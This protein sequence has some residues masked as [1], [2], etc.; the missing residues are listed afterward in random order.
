MQYLRSSR[1]SCSAIGF[2]ADQ[3]EE[4][5]SHGRKCLKLG[6]AGSVSLRITVLAVVP[7]ERSKR[8]KGFFRAA[9][10]HCQRREERAHLLSPVSCSSFRLAAIRASSAHPLCNRIGMGMSSE[11]ASHDEGNQTHSEADF[12]FEERSR[13]FGSVFALVAASAVVHRAFE[14]TRYEKKDQGGSDIVSKH[15]RGS[16]VLA[17]AFRRSSWQSLA[18]P[19]SLAS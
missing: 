8:C 9:S 19:L 10:R 4:R 3:R 12:E 13:S 11:D 15:E 16:P 1:D 5:G 18:R 17:P 2:S 6:V 7:G 14:L